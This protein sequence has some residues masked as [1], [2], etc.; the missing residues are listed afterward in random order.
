MR[1]SIESV[2]AADWLPGVA[3]PRPRRWDR[4]FGAEMTEADVDQLLL[5]LKA[6]GSIDPARFPATLTLQDII[7]ND[8]RIRR[9]EAGDIV[10]RKG[11]YGNAVF[12]V[13]RGT[14]RVLTDTDDPAAVEGGGPAHKR[15][16][17]N[18]LSQ[19]WRNSGVPEQRNIAAYQP[20]RGQ[21]VRKDPKGEAYGVVPDIDALIEAHPTRI[22]GEQEMFGEVAALARAPHVATVFADSDVELLELRWQGLRDI[23][24]RDKAFRAHI[25][26]LYRAS[27]LKA[28]L[29]ES[30]LFQRLDADVLELIATQTLFETHGDFDWAGGF[31]EIAAQDPSEVIRSEPVIAEHGDYVDG[32]LLIRSG[33]GRISERL[34]HGHRTVG[35]LTHNEVFGLP[36]I[37]DHWRDGRELRLRYGLRAVGFVDLLRVPTALVEEHVLPQLPDDDLPTPAGRNG[38]RKRGQADWDIEVPLEQSTINFLVN[39]RTI[40]GAAAMFI[41]TD[42]CTGCDECVRACAAAHDNNPRFVRHGPEHDHQM[43]AN[44]CMHCVDPVCLIGC[45]T[46]AI[47]RNPN[48]G[49]I[50]IDD[51]TCIGCA[52]CAESC[53]YDNIRMVE[54]RDQDGGFIVDEETQAPITK[55]TKCDLC[56]DQ[57]GGPACQR[58]CPHDALVRMDMRDRKQLVDWLRR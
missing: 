44:A 38:T 34:D 52:T 29:R 10:V 1:A 46:G 6:L 47:H 25:D 3:I 18:A 14:V 7:R 51:I 32:L 45:P 37:V 8:A 9:Y 41:N 36:E 42:R 19:L 50:V 24:R 23:R 31:K 57:P 56:F 12:I 5:T 55:A 21:G 20:G 58:A 49:L 22:L 13:I 17:F 39:N 54:I 48:D 28:H 33:F 16:V 26:A 40:N 4:P 2:V 11:D 53:P 15:S 27:S 35:Y 30:P 43:V